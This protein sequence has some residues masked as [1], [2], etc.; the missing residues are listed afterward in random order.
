[1]SIK[2]VHHCHCDP[3]NAQANLVGVQQFPK[4]NRTIGRNGHTCFE[5][6][7]RAS[8]IHIMDCSTAIA[9]CNESSQFPTHPRRTKQT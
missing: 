9:G 2:D 5:D 6:I 4:T 1:M 8:S 3:N 7:G